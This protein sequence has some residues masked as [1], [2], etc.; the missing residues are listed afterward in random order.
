MAKEFKV[1][2]TQQDL[3]DLDR[4]LRF[5]PATTKP[6]VLEQD[7]VDQFNRQGFLKPIDLFGA[8]DM[9]E[10]RSYFDEL[11]RSTLAQGGDSYSISSAHL[12]HSRVYDLLTDMRI[13]ALVADLLGENVVAWG[14]HF[15]LQNA[16]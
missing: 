3:N 14:S 6:V 12:K 10:I 5:Y 16:A 2:P 7:Q 9:I 4:D 11:L 1:V 13:V 15:F 8:E